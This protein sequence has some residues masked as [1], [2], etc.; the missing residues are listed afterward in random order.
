MHKWN[1]FALCLVEGLERFAFYGFL[2]SFIFYLGEHR[3]MSVEAAASLMGNFLALSYLAPVLGGVLADGVVGQRRAVLLG[4]GFLALGFA[5]LIFHDHGTFYPALAALVFGSGLFKPAVPAVLA[6]LYPRHTA[7]RE[8][9]FLLFYL[10]IQLGAFAA[11]FA[12][13]LARSTLGWAGSFATSAAAMTLAGLVLLIRRRHFAANPAPVAAEPPAHGSILILM[14]L[15]WGL[16][17]LVGN[18]LQLS[19]LFFA[20]DHVDSTL[21]GQLSSPLPATWVHVSEVACQLIMVPLVLGGLYYLQR[22]RVQLSLSAKAG[23]AMVLMILPCLIMAQAALAAGPE[24]RVSAFWVL[25]AQL[26]WAAPN[27]FLPPMMLSLISQLVPGRQLGTVF[28]VWFVAGMLPSKLMAGLMDT[29]STSLASPLW[30]GGLGVLALLAAGLWI[31]QVR[32]L[33]SALRPA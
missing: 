15:I 23:M 16:H 29:F 1:L 17:Q 3:G 22:K 7:G 32:R 25:G 10:A 18:G 27:V 4:I 5:L 13:E 2:A 28:A 26:A 30:F 9:G 20:R 11:P 8:T 31:S 24:L 33:E 12:S 19:M 21:G 6:N 14:Y